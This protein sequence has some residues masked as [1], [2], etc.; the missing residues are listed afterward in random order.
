MKPYYWALLAALAWGFAP[1]LE[2]FGLAK[3]PVWAG[4]FSRCLGV[5]LGMVILFLLRFDEIKYVYTDN[6]FSWLYLVGGGFLASI[7]G[8]VFFYSALKDGEVSQVVTIGAS[9]PLISFALGVLLL[10]EK[11]TLAKLGG[12]GFVVMGVLLLK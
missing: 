5:M 1:I 11:I 7:I 3:I 4:L 12:L 10:G 6:N 2:K 8:Q 9:Y